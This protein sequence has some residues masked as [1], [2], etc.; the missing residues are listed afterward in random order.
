MADTVHT[1]TLID[2][3]KTAVL[4]FTNV[5]DGTGESAVTKIDASA[6][7]GAP[8]G[9]R[10]EQVWWWTQGMGVNVLWDATADELAFGI[11][12]DDSGHADFR[13]F[14][15]LKTTAS[16]ATGDILFTTTNTPVSGDTYAVTLQVRK[17]GV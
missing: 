2:G 17:V 9:L 14:G 3:D 10:I 8:T 4:H 16:G 5:S 15:G 13:S 6:L 1:E 11:G 12:V 7:Q